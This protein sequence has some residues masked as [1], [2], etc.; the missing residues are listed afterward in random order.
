MDLT[1]ITQTAQDNDRLMP[2]WSNSVKD[3]FTAIEQ[4]IAF[5]QQ[6]LADL[7]AQLSQAFQVTP[8]GGLTVSVAGGSFK[9]TGASVIVVSPTTLTVPASATSYVYIND[10]GQVLVSTTR[11]A[12]GL[13]L[14][15][16]VATGVGISSI[17]NFP[18]FEVKQAINLSGY[19][20]IAYADS[21]SW[22]QIAVAKKTAVYN[23]PGRDVYYTIPFE[24]L[25][26]SGFNTGGVFT[27]PQG[28]KYK[29]QCQIRVDTL[30]TASTPEMSGKISL[31]VDGQEIGT[32]LQQGY[33]AFGDLVFNAE[34]AEPI[35]LTTA[36]QATIKVYLTSGTQC[37]VR[38]NSTV[39]AWRVP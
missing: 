13:E 16:V 10:S 39:V 9:T 38:E 30:A 8:T 22:Q 2:A 3:K 5:A 37:R 4:E 23:I 35:I 29:F 11:P 33:S 36:Q 25:Q 21:R 18:L 19:A 26:G 27:P 31:F 24:S 15:K 17:Q 28:G 34:N 1:S 20:T 7:K 6:Q 32:A 12:V 14:A